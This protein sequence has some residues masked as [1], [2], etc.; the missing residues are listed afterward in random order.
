MATLSTLN[1]RVLGNTAG[2][3]KS[4]D[5]AEGRLSK[6]KRVAGKALGAV[7]KGAA[8]LAI[9]GGAALVAFG[10]KAV[11]SFADAGDEIH[12]MAARTGFGTEALSE[13]KFAAEQSGA[14]LESVEKA[15]K[16]MASTIFDA[17]MGLV[18]AEDA[19]AAL[20]LT[21]EELKGL[22]P[23][24]QFQIIADKLGAVDD[25]S[26][27]A[28]IAQDI[29]GRSGAELIPLMNEGAEGMAALR[30]EA[31]DLGVV[32]SQ[33]A[34][35]SAADFKDAQNEL[36]SAVNGLFF[37]V[38]SELTPAI[39]AFTRFLV[40]NLP[41]IRSGIGSLAE[42]VKGFI[43]TARALTKAVDAAFTARVE[44]VNR[45]L[46]LLT[47]T[48][49]GVSEN[50]LAP[51]QLFKDLAETVLSGASMAIKNTADALLPLA[52]AFDRILVTLSPVLPQ[53]V[54]LADQAART[55]VNLQKPSQADSPEDRTT[56]RNARRAD[57]GFGKESLSAAH[58]DT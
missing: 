52:E 39:T 12:K 13:L 14:S 57:H 30:Q 1:V 42:G 4:L 2:L 29:F 45:L 36:K 58:G 31:R 37:A 49:I 46:G 28:A 25:A 56:P 19:L 44:E 6:F 47:Q 35:D 3:S 51:I 9:A 10:V 55:P 33:D 16:R 32:F 54:E 15:S 26:T 17:E 53:L 40:G 27:K 43:E 18:G 21:A 50:M 38:G 5:K 48:F 24:T 8:G 23:E 41:A 22:S 20:G 34:A 11:T 7:S